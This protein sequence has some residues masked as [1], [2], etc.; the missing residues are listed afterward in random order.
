MGKKKLAPDASAPGSLCAASVAVA[1]PNAGIGQHVNSKSKLTSS[2]NELH[3][4]KN[5]L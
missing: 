2:Q 1:Q 4:S 3:N 5:E